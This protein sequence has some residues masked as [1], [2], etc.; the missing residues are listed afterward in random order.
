MLF[1]AFPVESALHISMYIFVNKHKLQSW[2]GKAVF[3]RSNEHL[4]ALFY[5]ETILSC[6]QENLPVED[7]SLTSLF[8]VAIYHSPVS[9]VEAKLKTHRDQQVGKTHVD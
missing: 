9:D 4:C 8:N 7:K 1:C 6:S 5:P 2:D 3:C